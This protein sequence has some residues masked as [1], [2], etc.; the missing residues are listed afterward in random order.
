MMRGNI[1]SLLY[2]EVMRNMYV[3]EKQE[4]DHMRLTEFYVLSKQSILV[5]AIFD[6]A[7]L[8]ILGI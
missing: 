8:K 6:I 4:F 3:T 2:S 7:L 5:Q 1:N